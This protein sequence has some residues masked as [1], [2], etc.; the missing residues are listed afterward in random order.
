MARGGS[1]W[2]DVVLALG[3]LFLVVAVLAFSLLLLQ[4]LGVQ[5]PGAWTPYVDGAGG[6]VGLALVALGLYHRERHRGK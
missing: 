6:A 1:T 3:V 4:P 2:A 5:T